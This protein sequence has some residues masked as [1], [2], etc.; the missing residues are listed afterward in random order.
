MKLATRHK[1]AP[2][3]DLERILHAYESECS[4][5]PNGEDLYR[6]KMF[7]EFSK[8]CEDTELFRESEYLL[9]EKRNLLLEKYPELGKYIRAIDELWSNYKAGQP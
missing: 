7:H 1:F 5:R 3:P 8:Y 4:N 9:S 6:H 2:L